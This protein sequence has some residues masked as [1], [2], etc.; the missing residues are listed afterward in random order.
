MTDAINLL[1]D[2]YR[3]LET[4]E[5]LEELIHAEFPRRVALVSSF[6]ADAAI[7]LHMISTI[8][9]ATPV[10]FLDTKK[11]FGE[12]LTYR[13]QLVKQLGLTD[14]RSISPLPE[15]EA[16]LDPN[17]VLWASEPN[18]CCYFRKVLPLQRALEGFDAW[19]TGRKHYQNE[20][21]ANL[22]IFEM[23]DGRVKINPL[24]GWRPDQ[25]AAYYKAHSLPPHPLVARGYPSIGCIP[26][27]SPVT[28]DEDPRAGRWRG[29]AKTECGI[30]LSADGQIT[31]SVTVQAPRTMGCG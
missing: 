24:L 18:R 25:V 30:H 14:V 7:L 12:T 5:L 9:P 23:A 8:A 3:G 10:L 19:I 11:L 20:D 28:A 21:R 2:R 15:N 22:P 6:G 31:R 4:G 16:G 26:C 29:Q 27:T 13:D 1:S 17:G